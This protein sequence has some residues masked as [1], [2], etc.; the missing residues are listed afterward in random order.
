M[1]AWRMWTGINIPNMTMTL[2]ECLKLKRNLPFTAVGTW[3]KGS[4]ATAMTMAYT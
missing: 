4:A 3:I 2:S 1:R